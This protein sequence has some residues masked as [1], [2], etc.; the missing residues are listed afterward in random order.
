MYRDQLGQ[1]ACG[2]N[3]GLKGLIQTISIALSVSVF[4]GLDCTIFEQQ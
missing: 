4:A 2:Y 1:F 3:L